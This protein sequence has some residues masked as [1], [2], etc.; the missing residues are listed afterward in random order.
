MDNKRIARKIDSYYRCKEQFKE[1][2]IGGL[3][4]NPVARQNTGF[5]PR[6]RVGRN[7]LHQN[8]VRCRTFNLEP[9]RRYV[10]TGLWTEPTSGSEVWFMGRT[11]PYS[12]FIFEI[13]KLANV[14]QTLEYKIR[15]VPQNPAE[16]FCQSAVFL[17]NI[18]IERNFKSI[19][20]N[21]IFKNIN[22]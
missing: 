6:L 9:S 17:L 8:K 7:L 18:H 12:Y 20:K 11:S 1:N 10:G 4:A 14:W 3:R 16:K 22:S 13:R 2:Y 21:A 19:K 15:A 5:L